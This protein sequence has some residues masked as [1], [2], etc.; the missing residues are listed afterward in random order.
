MWIFAFVAEAH[1]VHRRAADDDVSYD[2][3]QA[4]EANDDYA[5]TDPGTNLY[6]YEI[7]HLL[8][9]LRGEVHIFKI[10]AISYRLLEKC[11]VA[12]A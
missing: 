12:Q 8:F 2:D 1:S 10:F 7:K 9:S 6:F 4:D 5:Q 11:M 3:T